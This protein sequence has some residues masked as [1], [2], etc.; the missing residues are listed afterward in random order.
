MQTELLK[1]SDA[2]TQ[3]SPWP[4]IN[5]I[6]DESWARV[7]PYGSDIGVGETVEWLL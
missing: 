7:F 5:Y 6:V 2:L 4:D 3:L 1:R